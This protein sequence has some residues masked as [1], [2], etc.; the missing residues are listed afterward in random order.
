LLRRWSHTWQKKNTKKNQNFDTL[1]PQP[2]QDFSTPHYT[3]KTGGLPCH[4]K[5]APNLLERCRPTGKQIRGILYSHSH[6]WDKQHNLLD[7]L[8]PIPWKKKLDD[9]QGTE[10]NTQQGT[11]SAPEKRGGARSS[12]LCKLSVNKA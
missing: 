9:K 1:N 2:V 10:K 5:P 8:T 6:C 11:L 4:Q 7:R 12:T 3:E